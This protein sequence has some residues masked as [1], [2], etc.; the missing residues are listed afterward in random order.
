MLDVAPDSNA[1]ERFDAFSTMRWLLSAVA[2]T[3]YHI[4]YEWYMRHHVLKDLYA[5]APTIWRY[6]RDGLF[7]FTVALPFSVSLIISSAYR[8]YYKRCAIGA[9]G[10]MNCPYR[11]SMKFGIWTGLLIGAVRAHNYLSLPI[12]GQMAFAL[13][14]SSVIRGIGTGIVLALV[15]QYI[16]PKAVLA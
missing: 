12:S 10:G 16:K 6:S 15:Y 14:L 1:L 7:P 8:N 2:I 9:V 5:E 13:F 11:K 3:A 4:A